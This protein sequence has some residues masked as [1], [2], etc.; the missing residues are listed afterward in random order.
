MKYPIVHKLLVLLTLL[1][2]FYFIPSIDPARFNPAKK[3]IIDSIYASDYE[4][5]LH[6]SDTSRYKIEVEEKANKIFIDQRKKS[7]TF[8]YM[9]GNQF[10]TGLG[11][12]KSSYEFGIGLLLAI[13]YILNFISMLG[14]ILRLKISQE[15]L[16]YCSF[17]V[18]IL[19]NLI[20]LVIAVAFHPFMLT[21]Y[22]LNFGLLFCTIIT[23][24]DLRA[25][26]RVHRKL[27][28]E[29]KKMD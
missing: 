20:L 24:F 8:P 28:E 26:N 3:A 2:P 4:T 14:I 17:G 15:W 7:N 12:I 19:F 21:Y 13:Y 29:I 27:Y 25:V 9:I 10:Q 6:I 23:I 18:I 5:G 22:I 11:L 1:L 16:T